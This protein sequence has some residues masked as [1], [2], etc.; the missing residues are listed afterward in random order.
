MMD[1]RRRD[2]NDAPDY[3]MASM[4]RFRAEKL[5]GTP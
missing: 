5:K 3:G 2:S 1:G 4:A